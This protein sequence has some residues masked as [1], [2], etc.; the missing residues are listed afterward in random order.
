MSDL[1]DPFDEALPE[2]NLAFTR[3]RS[4][5][6][7]RHRPPKKPLLTRC[8]SFGGR[9]GCVSRAAKM[10]GKWRE[11]SGELCRS[12][13]VRMWIRGIVTEI[14]AIKLACAFGSDP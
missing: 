14:P 6:R 7:V 4:A 13:S 11:K 1:D 5:V 3:Q 12:V 10:A 8:F 2:G 9:R